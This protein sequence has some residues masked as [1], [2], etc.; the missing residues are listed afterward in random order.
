[1]EEDKVLD[2]CIKDGD[3]G[4]SVN[5]DGNDKEVNDC[6]NIVTEQAKAQD[7]V[8]F[9]NVLKRIKRLQLV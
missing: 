7:K 5:E 4:S 6:N 9:G 3:V 1:M 2:E 8:V